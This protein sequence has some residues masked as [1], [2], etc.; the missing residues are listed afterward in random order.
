MFEFHVNLA[1]PRVLIGF[2]GLCYLLIWVDQA[3]MR[4][5]RTIRVVVGVERNRC[6]CNAAGTCSRPSLGA[7]LPI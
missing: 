2:F 7:L 3:I 4:F 6:W 5:T 1:I